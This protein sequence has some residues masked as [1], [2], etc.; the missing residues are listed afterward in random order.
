MKTGKPSVVISAER[1]S[2]FFVVPLQGCT[3]L[4][5]P[6]ASRSPDHSLQFIIFY[7]FSIHLIIVFPQFILCVVLC[8]YGPSSVQKYIPVVSLPVSRARMSKSKGKKRHHLFKRERQRKRYE[9]VLG[10]LR[11]FYPNYSYL[12]LRTII[13]TIYRIDFFFYFL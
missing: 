6:A 5:F 1:N 12:Y 11:K 7:V 2:F 3:V 4:C 10:H 13:R 8:L 9:N